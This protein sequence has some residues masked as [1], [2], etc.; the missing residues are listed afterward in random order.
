MINVMKEMTKILK[1][2]E[3][4]LDTKN[5]SKTMQEFMMQ[6]EKQE[7][8]SGKRAY[9]GLDIVEQIQEIM[10]DDD[11]DTDSDEATERIINEMEAQANGGHGGGGNKEVNK[12]D[13]VFFFI[14]EF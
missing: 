10:D 6:M 14:F 13:N 4:N 9:S 3:T 7:M 2:N 8:M 1:L 12:E 5:I 11:M